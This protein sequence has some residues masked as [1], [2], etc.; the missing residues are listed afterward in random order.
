MSMGSAFRPAM[1]NNDLPCRF[2]CHPHVKHVC[3]GGSAGLA[4]THDDHEAQAVGP[5]QSR[6]AHV[7]R[8]KCTEARQES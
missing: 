4:N 8:E 3:A 5:V 7:R 2:P 6:E 1:R